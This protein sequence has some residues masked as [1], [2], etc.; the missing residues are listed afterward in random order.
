MKT[1]TELAPENLVPLTIVQKP[2]PA[3]IKEQFRIMTFVNPRTESTSYRV[4]GWKRDGTRVRQNFTE[5]LEAQAKQLELNTEYLAQHTETALRATKLTETQVRLAEVAFLKLESEQDL[6]PAVDAWL[7]HGKAAAVG[8]T[9]RLDDAVTKF[10]AW[11]NSP[12][13]EFRARTKSNL[14]V[15]VDCFANGVQNLKLAEITPDTIFDYLRKRDVA[16][17]SKENDRRAISRFFA[18]CIDR[19]QRWLKANPARKETRERRRP[20]GT[21]PAI[22]SIEQCEKLLAAAQKHRSR[23]LVPYVAV[24]LFG[25]LRPFEAARL[26]WDAVNLKDREIRLE[27]WQTKTGRPR[28][29]VICDTLAAWLATAKKK[30][31]YPKNWRKDF[32]IVKREAGFG[33][34]ETSEQNGE[35]LQPWPEDVMRHTAISHY[36]RKTGSYGETAEW[37]GNSEAII[38][39]HYQGQV[40][41]EQTKAFYALMPKKG[42]R[43]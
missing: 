16:K 14:R 35:R 26:T 42:G 43:K 4:V 19:P 36:F 41:S 37:A 1:A 8:E 10:K 29:M 17:A 38:R 2:K 25:G 24:C 7:R 11:L 34:R 21:R 15:R 28:V 18:W 31:F 20:D 13:C 32:D 3:T 39:T 23:R 27:G 22:L 6:L 9:P 12:D 30:P 5:L 33:G 40:S